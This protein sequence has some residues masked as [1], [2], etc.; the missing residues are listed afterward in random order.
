MSAPEPSTRTSPAQ[1]PIVLRALGYFAVFVPYIVLTRW[2]ATVPFAPLGRPLSGLEILPAVTILSGI[3]TYLFVWR[4][5]WTREA[6]RIR[7]GGREWPRPTRWTALSGI[8]VALLLI[9]V[10][11]SFTFKGASIPFMQLLMRGDLLIVAP[12][13]DLFSG[14]RVRWYSW[15]AL[16]L[17][18]S[19][20]AVTIHARGGLRLPTL[21]IVV[22]A[23]YTVGYFIR[24][25]VMTRVAKSGNTRSVQGYFVEE[26]IVAIPVALAALAALSLADFGEQ[27]GQ[28]AFGFVGVW[29]AGLLG[30]LVVLA[31]L[32]FLISILAILILLDKRENSFCV[33]FE[34]SAS[35]LAGVAAAAIL[36]A[37]SFGPYP[38]AVELTG[39]GLLVAAIVLLAIAPNRSAA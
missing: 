14:R 25:W 8:G 20:L 6:H 28:L 34:R 37:M 22:V 33:P 23:L 39:A 31:A 5:G 9:T 1:M 27:H 16:L 12:A 7:I 17:V 32:L 24:L 3:C 19:G 29:Q 36:G 26:Q 15:I 4:Y 21:A 10:P 2:F 30:R 13:V 35:V 38:S 18:A 11:L